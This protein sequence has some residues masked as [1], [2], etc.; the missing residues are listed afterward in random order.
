MTPLSSRERELI[1]HYAAGRSQKQAARAMGI[2]VHT[3]KDYAERIRSKFHADSTIQA[4]VAAQR[5]GLL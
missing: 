4:V 2:S 3:A 5:M 1:Q